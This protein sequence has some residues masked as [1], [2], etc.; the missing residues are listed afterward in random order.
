MAARDSYRVSTVAAG[1][2]MHKDCVT[3][4]VQFQAQILAPVCP[5]WSD[6]VWQEILNQKTTV[7][8]ERFPN[9]GKGG[10]PNLTAIMEYVRN[11][12]SAIG[13]AE[14]SQVKKLAKGKTASFDPK[15]EKK[16]TIY[17]AKTWPAWQS[18]YIDILAK[19]LDSLGIVD[20]KTVLK[21]V[22]KADMKKAMP[23]IQG[24]KK[25]LDGGE[26]RE[27]VL[28]RKLAF[29]EEDV[30]SQMIPGLKATVAKLVEVAVVVVKDGETVP[31]AAQGAEPGAPKFEFVNV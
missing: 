1:M 19:Q 11:T 2:G 31:L 28:D 23:F 7:T 15:R 10:Q 21:S 9:Y 29:E 24:L 14:G 18:K 30:L 3:M 4:Y 16:L 6:S 12:S 22:E 17:C 20:T 13:S 27:Q 8:L 5:H 25:K 26:P